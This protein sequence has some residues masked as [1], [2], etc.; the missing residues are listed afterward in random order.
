MQ[1]VYVTCTAGQGNPAD[2]RF[3]ATREPNQRPSYD[4]LC[5]AVHLRDKMVANRPTPVQG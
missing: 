4:E 2:A 1:R 3:D 5:L